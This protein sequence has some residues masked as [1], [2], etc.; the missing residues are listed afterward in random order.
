MQIQIRKLQSPSIFYTSKRA[1]LDFCGFATS[2]GSFRFNRGAE[3][4]N[5]YSQIGLLFRSGLDVR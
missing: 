2:A 1:Q 4:P 3:D 5:E